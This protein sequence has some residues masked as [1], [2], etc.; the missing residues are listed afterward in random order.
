M[1]P[2]QLGKGLALPEN[3]KWI[4]FRLSDGSPTEWPTKTKPDSTGTEGW[5]R[6]VAIDE[7]PSIRWRA[8]VAQN[9]AEELGMPGSWFE[10]VRFTES[11]RLSVSSR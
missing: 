9:V 6:P 8:Q 1:P 7:G 3:P 11:D 10:F 2:R 4:E 5:Y